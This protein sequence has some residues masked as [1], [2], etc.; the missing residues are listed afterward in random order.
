MTHKPEQLAAAYLDGLRA[1]PRRR[2]E[3]HLLECE[4]CWDEVSLARLGR[5]LAERVAD[6]APA[7]TRE[8]IRAA[9]AAAAA[10]DQL[11]SG[12]PCHRFVLAAVALAVVV[13]ATAG[14][15]AWRPWQIDTARTADSR[16]TVAVAVASFRAD[17]LPGTAVPAQQPPDLASLG[18]RLVGASTGTL[19]GTPVTVFAY[20]NDDG[21]RLDLYHGTTP[22]PENGEAQEV[23]GTERA[24]STEVSGITVICGPDDHTE[25]LLSSDPQLVHAAGVLLAIV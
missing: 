5:A 2:Y 9:V 6:P 8:A 4:A 16:S 19:A 11:H 25:L 10:E 24:W 18:L 13:A 17:R 1:R 22:I 7:G 20:R 14:L 3:R 21:T 23:D 15:A 12:R